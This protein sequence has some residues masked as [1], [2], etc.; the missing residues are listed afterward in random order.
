MH[1]RLR[2]CLSF[3]LAGL[4]ASAGALAQAQQT[5]EIKVEVGEF[6]VGN[7]SRAGD[8]CGVRLRLTDSAI[9]QREVLIRIVL[10]DADGDRPAYTRSLTLNPGAPMDAWDRAPARPGIGDAGPWRRQPVL[11]AN[12]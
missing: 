11:P 10:A 2:L 6:G 12:G 9:K 8:W 3:L 1:S 5:D 7:V 4:F